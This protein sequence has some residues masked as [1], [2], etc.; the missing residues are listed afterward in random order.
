MDRVLAD[1]KNALLL[2]EVGLDIDGNGI[3]HDVS[4]RAAR[5]EKWIVLGRNGS[6]KTS[7]VRLLSGF[8]FPSRG[9]ME[10][11][12]ET[13]GRTDLHLLRR[14]VGWIH[15]DL[16]ADIPSFMTALEVVVSGTEGSLVVYEHFAGGIE[17]MALRMLESL[18][19]EKFAGRRFFRLST[20]ERQRVLI[21]RALAAGPELL[22]LDEPCQGLDPLAREEFLES[23]GRLLD[24]RRDLCVIFVTHHVDEI[25][26]GFSRVLV[27]E[28]GRVLAEGP[29]DEVLRPAMVK[30][31]FGERC[32]LHSRD[33]RYFLS[34]GKE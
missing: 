30:R 31:L 18:G 2:E 27:L 3:L 14:R 21:A 10:V 11:L 12:G 26:E 5:G 15:G 25:I 28:A 24:S 4:W 1:G 13:L 34:F 16:A 9:R 6:G 17:T 23:L 19:M 7:L 32:R 22:L 8:G 20:G 33:G 29:R